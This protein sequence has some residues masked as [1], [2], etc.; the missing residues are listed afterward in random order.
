M[1]SWRLIAGKSESGWWST[2]NIK[3]LF[4]SETL[5]IRNVRATFRDRCHVAIACVVMK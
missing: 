3:G 2:G 1:S 4:A 5:S